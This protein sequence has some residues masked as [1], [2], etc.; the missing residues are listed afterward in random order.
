MYLPGSMAL[1]GFIGTRDK[2][3]PSPSQSQTAPDARDGKPTEAPVDT[4]PPS[5]DP[6][7]TQGAL[8]TFPSADPFAGLWHA[9]RLQN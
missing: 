9:A 8:P 4:P 6:L 3:A 1:L 5:A 2:S 7:T